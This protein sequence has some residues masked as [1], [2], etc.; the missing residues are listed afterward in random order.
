MEDKEYLE[1]FKSQAIEILL[2]QSKDLA[3]SGT[4]LL[5]SEDINELWDKCAADYMADAVKE[6]NTYPEV[7]LAW[8]AYLGI[9]AAYA[10]DGDWRKSK[11]I[12]NFYKEICSKRG[13]DEMDE[14]VI[15]EIMGYKLKSYD[16]IKTENGMRSLASC[17]LNLMKKESPENMTNRAFHIFA[18]A[19][20]AM[21]KIGAN[22]ALYQ[23]GYK[24]TK[25]N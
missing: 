6:F 9:A 15:E 4:T 20:S 3:L 24:L 7:S 23:L 19:S 2:K 17:V 22:I 11:N 12:S 8:A 13:F 5:E 21:F 1:K 14:F 10:W 18:A 25:L 16:H